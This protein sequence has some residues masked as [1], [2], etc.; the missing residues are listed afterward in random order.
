MKLLFFLLGYLLSISAH[1]SD[2]KI[3]GFDDYLEVQGAIERNDVSKVKELLGDPKD[4]SK[5]AYFLTDISKPGGCRIE[6]AK[7][8]VE[9]GAVPTDQAIEIP[10]GK[11]GGFQQV[12]KREYEFSG[13]VYGL[14]VDMVKLYV[15]YVNKQEIADAAQY[16][17]EHTYPISKSEQRAKDMYQFLKERLSSDCESGASSSCQTLNAYKENDKLIAAQEEQKRREVVAA[18]KRES[19]QKAQEVYE[20]SPQAMVDRACEQKG[21]ITFANESLADQKQIEEESGV[22]NMMARRQLAAQKVYATKALKEIQSE[23][24]RKYGAPLDMRLCKK[25]KP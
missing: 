19:D 20:K 21:A 22:I 2:Y 25:T 11:K 10:Y 18:E 9:K 8:F 17:I 15:P 3:L 24:Q 23:Y 6:L 16:F 5:Y 12:V 4:L 13:A 1:A 14:C 7:L